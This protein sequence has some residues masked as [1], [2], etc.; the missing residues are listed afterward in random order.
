[1]IIT[2]KK[3]LISG[4]KHNSLDLTYLFMSVNDK[5]QNAHIFRNAQYVRDDHTNV[6]EL[7][8]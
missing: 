6:I 7:K 4:S 3:L 8:K 2:S 5:F 1:M